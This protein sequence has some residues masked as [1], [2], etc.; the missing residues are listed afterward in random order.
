MAGNEFLYI[1]SGFH[2]DCLQLLELFKR[3][4]SYTFDSF[5]KAWKEMKFSLVFLCRRTYAEMLE[6]CE[7]ALNIAK[8]IMLSSLEFIDQIGGL[9]LLYGL[10]YK[11]P[12]EN[13]KIRVTMKEW[14]TILQFHEQIKQEEFY[15]TSYILVKLVKDNAFCHCLFTSEY[16]IEKSF[17]PHQE[18]IDNPY[19]VL[20]QIVQQ[21]ED[22]ELSKLQRLSKLYNQQKAKLLN[23]SSSGKLQL[24][25]KNFVDEILID[26]EHVEEKRQSFIG[27]RKKRRDINLSNKEKK[28]KLHNEDKIRPKLGHAFDTDSSD[29]ENMQMK[30]TLEEEYSYSLPQTFDRDE[31]NEMN[32]GD[33]SDNDHSRMEDSSEKS[34]EGEMS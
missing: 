13:V 9:Y 27:L 12:I 1:A 15:D 16:G 22:G 31:D 33:N 7:E 6:F 26:V 5:C 19:S 30:M 28:L 21:I 25:D 34:Y 8:Q 24:F 10:F 14:R 11:I 29:D 20:P 32:D 23:N 18:V 4:E 17:Q 3:Y 2:E